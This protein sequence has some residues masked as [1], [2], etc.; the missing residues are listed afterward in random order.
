MTKILKWPNTKRTKYKISNVGWFDIG[1]PGPKIQ[2]PKFASCSLC[3]SFCISTHLYIVSFVFWFIII[4][5]LFILSNLYFGILVFW[6]SLLYLALIV[7]FHG[8]ILPSLYFC[9]DK[10]KV[11]S[12]SQSQKLT[13]WFSLESQCP[14]TPTPTPEKVSKKQDRAILPK[15]EL[16]IYVSRSKKCFWT[17]PQP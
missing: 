7:F 14:T 17:W 2:I 9:I 11:V 5:L 10:P 13:T 8:L 12:R 1:L 16:L 3:M 4:L 15:Q 6:F